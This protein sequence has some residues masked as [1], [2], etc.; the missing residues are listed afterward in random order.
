M[1]ETS[2]VNKNNT[3]IILDVPYYS[4]FDEID[5]SS[6]HVRVFKRRSCGIVSVKM[7]LDY[8]YGK[9]EIKKITLKNLIK[10]A[11]NHRAYS[12]KEGGKKG[13]GW[14]HSG[15]VRT[16]Q[17]LGFLS[18]RRMWFLRADDKN[19]F[20]TEGLGSQSLNK[21][22]DQVKEETYLSFRKSI[23]NG[24]PFLVSINKNLG[25]KKCPHL[26]VVT[27]IE[28]DKKEKIM[29]LYLNDPHNPKNGTKVR[30]LYKDQFISVK[31]FDKIWRKR[32]IFISPN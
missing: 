6:E 2:L 10:L 20:K 29:G 24:N 23:E 28:F 25:V 22:C 5:G 12:L 19:F 1:N 16:L 15:M 8:F 9:G 26:V 7:V 3:S 21:Y 17:D 31:E 13:K 27:G 11:L 30:P 32:A 4:E 14:V 18:W